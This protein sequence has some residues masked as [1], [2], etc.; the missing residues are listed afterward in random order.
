MARIF[1]AYETRRLSAYGFAGRSLDAYGE[2]P[3][4]YLTGFA[5]FC[6]YEFAVDASVM[7]PR[8]ETE[9]IVEMAVAYCEKLK[10]CVIADIGTGSGCIGIAVQLELCKRGMRSE[11]WLADIS[12][13]ALEIAKRNAARLFG[14]DSGAIHFVKSDLLSGFP[15]GMTFDV[16]L[17]N[18][19]YVPQGRIVGLP[20][21]VRDFEPSLALDGGKDGAELI[22]RLLGQVAKRM[23]PRGM[24]IAEVDEMHA[25]DRFKIPGGYAAQILKDDFG[26]NRFL[27]LE[28]QKTASD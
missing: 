14:P 13:Q 6:G 24:L 1:S 8:I 27:A 26:K 7:I 15:T 12:P 9:A 22:N 4:E 2:M 19:P 25:L 18:L 5:E 28:K 17:A 20:P 11:M 3:V 21:S 23:N 16:I 10:H